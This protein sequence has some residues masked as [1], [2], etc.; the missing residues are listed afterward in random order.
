MKSNRLRGC[1][2]AEGQGAG[3]LAQPCPSAGLQ[4]A[5]SAHG[6]KGVSLV[7]SRV[8]QAWLVPSEPPPEPPA[9]RPCVAP[10]PAVAGRRQRPN[11]RSPS[12][13]RRGRLQSTLP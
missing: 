3:V 10:V 2:S 1:D 11:C 7:N 13:A 5:D 12:L 9:K 4:H 8:L 6:R